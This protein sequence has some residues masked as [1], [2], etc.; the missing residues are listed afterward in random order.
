MNNNHS[1]LLLISLRTKW[2]EGCKL[3][4]FNRNALK[5][6]Y[7]LEMNT[8]ED[9]IQLV[10]ADVHQWYISLVKEKTIKNILICTIQLNWAVIGGQCWQ[11]KAGQLDLALIGDCNYGKDKEMTY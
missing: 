3:K 5:R 9:V 7:F 11:T 1:M 8:D 10:T 2:I 6:I 4:A